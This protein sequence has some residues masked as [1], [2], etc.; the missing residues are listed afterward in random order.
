MGKGVLTRAKE[1]AVGPQSGWEAAVGSP[2]R[3]TARPL[4]RV[5]RKLGV[6]MEVVVV[7]EGPDGRELLRKR[8]R[9]PFSV[10]RGDRGVGGEHGMVPNAPAAMSRVHLK[11]D[12]DPS[13]A[14]IVLHDLSSN[15]VSVNGRLLPQKGA[16]RFAPGDLALFAGHTMRIELP[17]AAAPN[18]PAYGA[19][20][21]GLPGAEPQPALGAALFTA[22]GQAGDAA[23]VDLTRF[24][25]R[26]RLDGAQALLSQKEADASP[27]ALLAAPGALYALTGPGPFAA[28]GARAT[29]HVAAD[30]PAPVTLN[31]LPLE[32]GPRALKAYD[33]VSVAGL[34]VGILPAGLRAIRCHNPECARLNPYDPTLNCQW[35]GFR[36]VEGMTVMLRPT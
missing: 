36:L 24:S 29:V 16:S 1:A 13:G 11:L 28:G 10:G 19:P 22:S 32:P 17:Q 9:P 35:C 23:S 33:L 8:G 27:E 5:A 4:R 34:E 2:P 30:A 21:G 7:V 12:L 26:A 20:A 18:P 6:E 31:R 15:G 14:A 3:R 25:A